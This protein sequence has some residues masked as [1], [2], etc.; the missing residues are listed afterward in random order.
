VLA[1]TL[2]QVNFAFTVQIRKGFEV[3]LTLQQVGICDGAISF[4]F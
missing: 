2:P 3:K 4:T 1:Y